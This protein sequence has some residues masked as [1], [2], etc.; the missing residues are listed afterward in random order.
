M[1]ALV[2]YH[3]NCYDGF[4][5]AWIARQAMPDCELFKGRYGEDP[6]YALSQERDVYIVDF[7]YPREQMEKLLA[8]TGAIGNLVVL[9]HHKTAEAA[10]QGLSFCTFDMERSG[11]GMTW[12]HFNEG[13]ERPAWIDRVEDRDLW[14][15]RC[16]NTADVHAFIASLP[17]T[18]ENWDIID[19]FAI[20]QVAEGGRVI[21]RYIETS[22]EKVCSL[23][24][25][26]VIDGVT[27]VVL[28]IPFLNASETAT[29][30]L[31]EHPTAVYSMTYSQ[32]AD[33][34]WGYSLRCRSGFDVSGIAKLHGGGGHAE[35]AG[36]ATDVLM[37]QLL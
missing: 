20:E 34:R 15:W 13:K 2:I 26:I 21:N 4:T 27:V 7:S 22:I 12:D 16:D 6:P 33:G 10:C 5:A 9:D 23:A 30:L 3:A 32:G 18:M 24:R 1:T 35:A 37:S 8:M 28:N 14:R 17:M 11:A 31:F 19:S 29:A 36:F 25:L